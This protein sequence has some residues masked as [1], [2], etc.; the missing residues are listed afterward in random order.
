M[1]QTILALAAIFVF[2]IFALNQHRTEAHTEQGA[3]GS[4]IEIAAT[5]LAQQQLV[6][7]GSLAFDETIALTVEASMK[8]EVS[9][10]LGLDTGETIDIHDDIDDLHGQQF[11]AS[12]M[13]DG[14]ALDFLVAVNVRYVNPA[15]PSQT[16]GSPTNLKEVTVTVT[17][18]MGTVSGRP[19][20]QAS[21]SQLF[22]PA[23]S[24]THA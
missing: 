24:L 13:R 23:W 22:T 3:I 18:N 17:E 10:T 1:S 16:S 20:V 14:I 21:L 7:I 5:N 19:S 15:D 11:S 8:P 2:S 9:S 6:D 12:T 4:E